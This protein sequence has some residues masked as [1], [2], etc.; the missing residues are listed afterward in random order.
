MSDS[1]YTRLLGKYFVDYCRADGSDPDVG[2]FGRYLRRRDADGDTFNIFAHDG[3]ESQYFS[4]ERE[5]AQS[6]WA[7]TLGAKTFL[8][9][10]PV[11]FDGSFGFLAPFEVH[12]ADGS[13]LSKICPANMVEAVPAVLLAV[14]DGWEVDR[15]GEIVLSEASAMVDPEGDSPA[16]SSPES[17]P[18]PERVE[19]ASIPPVS[20]IPLELKIGELFTK[21][22][23]ATSLD[24]FDSSNFSEYVAVYSADES[25]E[26]RRVFLP[27]SSQTP[28]FI[29]LMDLKGPAIDY[30]CVAKG[31]ENFLLPKPINSESFDGLDGFDSSS[32]VQP[33]VIRSCLPARLERKEEHWVISRKGAL[34]VDETIEE[35]IARRER[36]IGALGEAPDLLEE[37][38]GFVGTFREP[39]L[40]TKDAADETSMETDHLE[41]GVPDESMAGLEGEVSALS[42]VVGYA[43]DSPREDV[44][45]VISD[46][47][48]PIRGF[49]IGLV[50]IVLV[51]VLIYAICFVPWVQE[52]MAGWFSQ[53]SSLFN[54]VRRQ[55]DATPA[56]VLP[57]ELD[58]AE[59]AW[60]G[61]S[62]KFEACLST[63]DLE[64]LNQAVA[65][66]PVDFQGVDRF[67]ERSNRVS[68]T[69]SFASRFTDLK[70]AGGSMAAALELH[71]EVAKWSRAYW[72]PD[73]VSDQRKI[74]VGLVLLGGEMASLEAKE[75]FDRAIDEWREVSKHFDFP[76]LD[77]LRQKTLKKKKNFDL[78]Q[79]IYPM[80]YENHDYIGLARTLASASYDEDTRETINYYTMT[81]SNYV[82]L[83]TVLKSGWDRQPSR[84]ALPAL[85]EQLP[86]LRADLQQLE[87]QFLSQTFTRRVEILSKLAE[88]KLFLDETKNQGDASIVQAT[89]ARLLAR[90]RQ[91]QQ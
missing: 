41:R 24:G 28:I 21:F 30:W 73:V 35:L 45:E 80:L 37:A 29:E 88:L 11:S 70:G 18:E 85:V 6:Y 65:Q 51:S 50:P 55:S 63:L 39:A 52:P 44:S 32:K 59:M 71:E 82:M 40:E 23:G 74:L 31:S 60:Q 91:R 33:G 17:S 16:E 22:C 66:A 53:A 86:T 12:S 3:V 81:L 49:L 90:G 14:R 13:A 5:S 4:K 76:E 48:S 42:E 8:F 69:A 72:F 89:Q 61:W 19:A 15:P 10:R 27:S 54:G 62:N 75:D 46:R 78:E 67:I 9:P 43:D 34:S 84:R 26:I 87:S 20:E 2:D 47:R 83:R 77:E 58:S 1:E 25:F 68:R 36:E 56:E 38:M 79:R 57:G 7:L 64:C